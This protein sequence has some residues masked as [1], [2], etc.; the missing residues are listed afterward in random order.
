MHVDEWHW[1]S[2]LVHKEKA[3]EIAQEAAVL[4]ADKESVALE[5]IDFSAPV[6]F[7]MEMDDDEDPKL[8]KEKRNNL[9]LIVGSL[10]RIEK[11]GFKGDLLAFDEKR[12]TLQTVT[13]K[14]LSLCDGE[15]MMADIGVI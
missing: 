1:D 8:R 12:Y 5:R 7:D 2:Q 4:K 9:R 14:F 3:V 6:C 11:A 15:D 10:Y 13:T